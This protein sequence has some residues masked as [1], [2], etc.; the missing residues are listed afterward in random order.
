MRYNNKFLR[1]FIVTG[2]NNVKFCNIKSQIK[3]DDNFSSL[4]FEL[5]NKSIITLDLSELL[6]F[7]K[8]SGVK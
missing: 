7:C 2:T 3:H 4:A 1:A 8:Q 6:E 5:P